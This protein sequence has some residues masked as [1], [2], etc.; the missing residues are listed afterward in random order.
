[1]LH[2][3]NGESV[4]STFRQSRFP[5]KYLS[6]IDVLH[7]GPVP[8]TSTLEELSDVRARALAD[9]GAGEYQ[10]IR[11]SFA[12]R[13]RTLN[14][15]RKHEEV[16]LWFEHDLFD[17]L[18]LLQLLDWFSD[19]DPGKT[20]TSLV[21]V[22]SY[23]GVQPFYGLGQLSATQLSKLFPGRRTVT[24]EQFSI[25]REVWRAFRAASPEE[26]LSLAT[27]DFPEMPFL[28]AALLRF[29]EEYPWTDDGLSRSQR[30]LLRAVQSGAATRREI[31]SAS[32]KF[33]DC[34]WGDSSVFL[35]LDGLTMGQAPALKKQA[36]DQYVLTDSGKQLLSGQA[37]WLKL[38]GGID[39]WLGGVH[40]ESRE[41]EWRWDPGAQKL[42]VT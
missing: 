19:Q 2:I 14:E 5:G 11:E 25:G 4:I 32:Q 27:G 37:N 1:V 30:Q 17:Q 35:R 20:R 40:L 6:W 13:D 26:L 12:Q 28:G 8:Q 22:N 7:D 9:F 15:F 38:C 33:E 24:T 10:K 3:S 39:V 34:P 29:V 41:P 23:P 36:A 31:Y 18:Q 42:V 16:V 21:Q